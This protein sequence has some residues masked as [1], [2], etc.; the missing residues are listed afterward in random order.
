MYPKYHYF[1][2]LIGTSFSLKLIRIHRPLTLLN[3]SEDNIHIG[4]LSIEIKDQPHFHK[5]QADWEE[6]KVLHLYDSFTVDNNVTT[7]HNPSSWV[8]VTISFR[9]WIALIKKHFH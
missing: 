5:E 4:G 1:I 8:N 2:L 9:D 6:D 3:H 7:Q